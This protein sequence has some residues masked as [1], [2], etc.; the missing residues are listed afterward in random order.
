[1][2]FS[3]R[4]SRAT[5]YASSHQNNLFASSLSGACTLSTSS[6]FFFPST[7]SSFFS[8]T[9]SFS[10]SSLAQLFPLSIFSLFSS[11]TSFFFPSLSC[12]TPS[13]CGGIVIIFPFCNLIT[14][15]S[16]FICSS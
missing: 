16:G 3:N 2:L 11:F 14:V 5:L 1:L 10:L 8:V 13:S 15:G 4:A 7:V 6:S 12:F 9:F